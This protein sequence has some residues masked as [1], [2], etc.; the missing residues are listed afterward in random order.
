M[1]SY[2]VGRQFLLVAI[3]LGI[4][5]LLPQPALSQGTW[6]KMYWTD[7]GTDK[8]Q[9]ADLDGMNVEDPVNTGL[10]NPLLIAF[11]T[12]SEFVIGGVPTLAEW[13]M[14]I[15]SMLLAGT[16]LLVT[17]RRRRDRCFR[18]GEIAQTGRFSSVPW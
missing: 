10:V 5:M 6:G 8:I 11:D 12:Q 16:A 3:V 2:P 14:I 9:R 17:Y 18:V 15:L 7:A 4:T 13:G 1:K